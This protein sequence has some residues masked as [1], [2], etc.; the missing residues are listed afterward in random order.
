MWEAIHV[1]PRPHRLAL[2]MKRVQE[3]PT[4]YR[5]WVAGPQSVYEGREVPRLFSTKLGAGFTSTS[6]SPTWQDTLR[7]LK[8]EL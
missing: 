5:H 6:K 3:R 4:A 7:W 2:D 8:D 1:A